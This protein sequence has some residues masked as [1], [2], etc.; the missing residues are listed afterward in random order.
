[1][2]LYYFAHQHGRK[3]AGDLKNWL[4]GHSMCYVKLYISNMKRENHRIL[5]VTIL[6]PNKPAET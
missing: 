3:P 4:Q 1:M 5:R 2:V 6:K